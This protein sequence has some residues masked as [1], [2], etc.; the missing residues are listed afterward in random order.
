MGG[1]LTRGGGNGHGHSNRGGG[2][3]GRFEIFFSPGLA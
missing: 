1:S 2:L 3:R